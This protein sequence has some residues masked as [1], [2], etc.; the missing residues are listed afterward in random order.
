MFPQV[1]LSVRYLL[2][3]RDE[4]LH[5]LPEILQASES[6]RSGLC[7]LSNVCCSKQAGGG[8]VDYIP[9]GWTTSGDG[10]KRSDDYKKHDVLTGSER[11]HRY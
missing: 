8:G 9:P 6:L 3:G 2:P 1:E 4:L 7:S 5:R 10:A 11:R